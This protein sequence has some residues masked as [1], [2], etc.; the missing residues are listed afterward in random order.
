MAA[1]TVTPSRVKQVFNHLC[2]VR[3]HLAAPGGVTK[4]QW[5]YTVTTSGRV[6]PGNTGSAGKTK[7]KGI[8]LNDAG[9]GQAVDVLEKGFADGFELG[10]LAYEADIFPGATD[11]VLADTISNSIPANGRVVAISDRDPA[12]GLP[13]KILQIL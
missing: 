12:T 5:V 9:D 7:S 1:I 8:A 11:G 6:G 2:T 10:G 13:S 4:G 3:T